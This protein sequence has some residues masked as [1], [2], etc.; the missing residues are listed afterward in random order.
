MVE[1]IDGDDSVLVVLIAFKTDGIP[2]RRASWIHEELTNEI[3]TAAMRLVNAHPDVQFFTSRQPND[4]LEPDQRASITDLLADRALVG[5]AV[6]GRTTE[7]VAAVLGLPRR[8]AE[9]YLSHPRSGLVQ[10]TDGRW[11]PKGSK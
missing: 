9:N 1:D 2:E 6:D 11:L 5:G 4:R 7:E 3:V 8:Q 10:H